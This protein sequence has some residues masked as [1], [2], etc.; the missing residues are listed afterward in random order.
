MH[1]RNSF[2]KLFTNN[3][4]KG[5]KKSDIHKYTIRYTQ[6]QER[7]CLDPQGKQWGS[8]QARPME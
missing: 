1:E 4:Q 3:H 2:I 5:K 6:Q 8:L 7:R